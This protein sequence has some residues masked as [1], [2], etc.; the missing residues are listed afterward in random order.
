MRVMVPAPRHSD[1]DMMMQTPDLPA[2]NHV[3]CTVSDLDGPIRWLTEVLGFSFTS[4]AGRPPGLAEALTGVRG[5]EVEIA[6]LDRPGLRLELLRYTLPDPVNGPLP[7][8][9]DTGAM[10][11]ALTVA[12]VSSTLAASAS[13]GVGCLGAIVTVP[14]GPNRGARVAYLR[15]PA[16][17]MVELI[18][19]PAPSAGFPESG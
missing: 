4:R 17:L 18:Q 15:H 8:P 7:G 11:L 9:A 12:S 13:Y 6:F 3:G 19:N 5:A 14:E 2:L 1:K 10:H 16:G